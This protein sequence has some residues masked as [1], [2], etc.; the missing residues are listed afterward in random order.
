MTLKNTLIV[1]GLAIILASLVIWGGF[2]QLQPVGAAAFSGGHAV[3]ATTSSLVV[4]PAANSQSVW[5]P[6]PN[7]LT[8]NNCSARIISTA[9]QA[10]NISFSGTSSSTA[11]T[12]VSNLLG[13]YQPASTTVAYDG[14]I[15]GCRWLG[16]YGFG[17]SSTVNITST[18]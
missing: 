12:T 16:F 14:G 6:G 18:Q 8:E 11:T 13:H 2:Y 15:Y 7:T 3:V 1:I 10:V 17:A 4:G 9:N 5:A